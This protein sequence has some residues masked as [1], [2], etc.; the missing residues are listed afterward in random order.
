MRGS[1]SAARAAIAF[2]LMSSAP[3]SAAEEKSTKPRIAVIEFK[4]DNQSWGKMDVDALLWSD[5][6]PAAGA[7]TKV[8]GLDV[9]WDV[10]DSPA[11]GV[12]KVDSIAIKQ[13][14]VEGKAPRANDRLR[15]AGPKDDWGAAG[16]NESLT[17]GGDRTETALAGSSRW[18]NI[19]LKRGVD[20]SATGG[21]SVAA[22]D[23]DGD[24]AAASGQATGKR[25]H[26]PIR[27]RAYDSP[28]ANGSLLIRLA[29]PWPDCVVG[30]RFNGAYLVVGS[31]R[32]YNLQDATVV[33]CPAKA[34]ML[35]YR[36]FSG[37][38]APLR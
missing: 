25:Q 31:T 18:K 14:T 20:R 23:L 37:A 8:D 36:R 17:V 10:S 33:G 27:I 13:K 21:V 15:T 29:E 38:G 1:A 24:G 9:S 11:A 4:N 22:G 35:N 2:A 32:R 12:N 7:W 6:Q 16:A 26:M 34:V 3:A 5:T 28:L 30:D 19:V